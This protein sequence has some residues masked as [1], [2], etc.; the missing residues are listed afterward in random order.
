MTQ[1][2]PSVDTYVKYSRSCIKLALLFIVIFS[3]IAML[4]FTPFVSINVLPKLM[5]LLPI[6]I[7]VAIL[8]LQSFK[9]KNGLASGS[10][11]FKVV[12][13]DELRRQSIDKAYRSAFFVTITAQ[14]PLSLLLNA[15]ALNHTVL[16]LGVT[17]LILGTSAF[18]VFFLYFDK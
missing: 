3:V 15:S 8:W 2:I 4:S 6:F 10:E 17:T 1:N 16:I 5:T 11:A 12:F 7:I 14:I 9:K 13:A 18:L